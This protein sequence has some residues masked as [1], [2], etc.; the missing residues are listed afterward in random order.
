MNS[1]RAYLADGK[2]KEARRRLEP[3]AYDP[4]GRA[5]ADAA[6]AV[7]QKIDAGDV[8]GALS[9]G[10]AANRSRAAN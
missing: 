5:L 4:H 1:A 6:R 3:V 7:I 10:E 8:K 2:I 9:S